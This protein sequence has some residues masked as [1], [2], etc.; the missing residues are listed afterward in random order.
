MVII[1]FDK[2]YHID[3][4]KCPVTYVFKTPS[5]AV[6]QHTDVKNLVESIKVLQYIEDNFTSS[7]RVDLDEFLDYLSS[8]A[9]IAVQGTRIRLIGIE[10]KTETGKIRVEEDGWDSWIIPN[11]E[12]PHDEI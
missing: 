3:G 11:N 4:L 9:E 8:V 7:E 1:E 10:L 12:E 2:M 6:F 5:I